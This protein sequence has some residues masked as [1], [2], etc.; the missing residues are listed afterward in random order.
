MGQR[1]I[2]TRG[3]TIDLDLV[4]RLAS[5]NKSIE[6]SYYRAFALQKLR[7]EFVL[8]YPVFRNYLKHKELGLLSVMVGSYAERHRLEV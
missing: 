7:S 8:S 5:S 3:I 1:M 6:S 2:K 4:A